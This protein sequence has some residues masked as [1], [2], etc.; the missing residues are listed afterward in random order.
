ME[1]PRVKPNWLL[2]WYLVLLLI[3]LAAATTLASVTVAA[4]VIGTIAGASIPLPDTLLVT[5]TAIVLGVLPWP[6]LLMLAAAMV[7]PQRT[8]NSVTSRPV[9]RA[10]VGLVALNEEQAVADAV[11]DFASVRGVGAVIVVDNRSRDRTAEL[12]ARAGARVVHEARRGYGF[13]CQRALHEGLRSGHP[14]VV[15]CEADRTFRAD[16]LG[17]LTA[18]LKHA[19]LVIGSRTHYALLKGDSQMNS[20]LTLGNV[21]VGKVLQLR[22]WDWRVGGRARLTD[23]GCTYMAFRAD[24]LARIV[25]SLEV[26]GNH[27]VPHVLMVAQEHGLRV[28]QVPVTFWP[29]VGTSKGGS[30]GWKQGLQLGL[31]MLWHI[32]TYR[33]KASPASYPA[34]A[35]SS[36]VAY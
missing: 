35:E 7:R 16:D 30:A 13:A 22:Y 27:F 23:V 18:Y 12:A 3:G 14:A 28:V 10:V 11:R 32:L 15:L 25:H 29:R 24:A 17:K 21:F 4:R 5:V 2:L 34:H 36:A 26:G 19:D 8:A 1:P 6:G 9:G 31:T 20:F 33:V